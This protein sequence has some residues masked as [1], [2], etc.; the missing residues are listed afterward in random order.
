M[1]LSKKSLDIIKN[2]S[3]IN[4]GILFKSGKKI[5]TVSPK[6][7]V[8]AEAILSEDITADFSIYDLN[9]FLSVVSLSTEDDNTNSKFDFTD[10]EVVLIGMKGRGKTHYAFASKNMIVTPPDNEINFP[11]PEIFATLTKKDKDWIFSQANALHLPDIGVMS[12][13]VDIYMTASDS[14][15]KS[16][17]HSS[18][19]NIGKGNGDIY[20]V[21]FKIEYLNMIEGDY[22]IQI[23]S[24]GV[25]HWKNKDVDVQYWITTEPGSKYQKA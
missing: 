25:A 6:R 22:D 2:F 5:K 10:N 8:L 15:S 12:D 1:E 21:N 13:G 7:N 11:E 17:S 9:Q 24:K 20:S 16:V 19:L 23:S 18:T 4:Q 14:S 3:Q